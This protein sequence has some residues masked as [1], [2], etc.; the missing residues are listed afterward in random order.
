[1]SRYSKDVKIKA[2]RQCL[3]SDDSPKRIADKLGID[4]SSFRKWIR[5]YEWQPLIISTAIT[6]PPLINCPTF[7]VQSKKGPFYLGEKVI[8]NWEQNSN[9]YVFGSESK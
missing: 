2:I 3:N 8:R 5:H 4:F 9:L 7:G 6:M 1:M